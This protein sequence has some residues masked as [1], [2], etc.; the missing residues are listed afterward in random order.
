M[1]GISAKKSQS[2]TS[3]DRGQMAVTIHAPKNSEKTCIQEPIIPNRSGFLPEKKLLTIEEFAQLM[4]IKRSTA[5]SWL[6]AGRLETGRHVLRIGGIVRIVWSDDLFD[7]LLKQSVH[8]ETHVQ[9]VRKGKGGRNLCAL[10]F[11]Y[12]ESNI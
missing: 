11:K 10:D 5:Y 6:A 8:K 7:Y 1:D 2:V 9:L 4:R 12:L 3:L